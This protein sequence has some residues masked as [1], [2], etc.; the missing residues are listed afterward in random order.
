MV[1]MYE[2]DK[3]YFEELA[4]EHGES[5]TKAIHGLA[6]EHRKKSFFSRLRSQVAAAQTTSSWKEVEDERQ[7]WEST[8]NDGLVE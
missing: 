8:I 5:V 7:L 4:K 3:D 2:T 6:E 1:R